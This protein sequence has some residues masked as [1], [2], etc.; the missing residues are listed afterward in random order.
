[1]SLRMLTFCPN[2]QI[3]GFY[4]LFVDLM[5]TQISEPSMELVI[6]LSLFVLC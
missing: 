2:A 6:L 4:I 5:N 3:E 1:M